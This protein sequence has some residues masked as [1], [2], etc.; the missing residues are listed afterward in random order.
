MATYDL[1]VLIARFEP[2]HLGHCAVLEQALSHAPRVLALIGSSE[3][4]RTPQ[5]P[6]SFEERAEMIAAALGADAA[7]VTILPLR[8]HLYNAHRWTAEAQTQVARAAGE[9]QSIALFCARD[10]AQVFPQWTRIAVDAPQAP[11]AKEFRDALFSDARDALRFFE[12]HAPAPVSD[13]IARFRQTEAFARLLEEYRVT[14]ADRAAWSCAPFPPVFV[15][16]DA[17]VAHSGHVLLVE[18]KHHP[19]RGLWALPGGFVEQDET[20]RDAAIRELREE[21]AIGLPDAALLAHLRGSSVFDDPQRSLRG[22]TITNAFFFDFS[23]GE[24]PKIHSGDDAARARWV[25]LRDIGPMRTQMFEDHFS[26]LEY[27]LATP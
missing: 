9:G 21:T 1:A 4:A 12:E 16:V 2:V 8:D 25:P 20:L 19:G 3:R 17:V 22:R 18:R 11:A 27:F 5:H 10:V 6:W 14:E 24:L 26:I 23:S 13:F 15:T 7:R